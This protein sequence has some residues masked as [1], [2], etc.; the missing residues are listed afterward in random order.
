MSEI[1]VAL[2]LLVE[3]GR[4]QEAADFYAAAFGAQKVQ[5]YTNDGLLMGVDLLIGSVPI[6]VSGAN[7][8][9]QANPALGGPFHPQTAG[10]VTAVPLLTVSDI[11]AA[12]ATALA[13]GATVRGAI[14]PD[15]TGSR[16]ATLFDPFGHIWGLTERKATASRLAA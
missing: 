12:V 5:D 16:C 15:T 9:R 14:E 2:S 4:E 8:K 13:A 7:P 6:S 3:H 11:D 1:S 10:A